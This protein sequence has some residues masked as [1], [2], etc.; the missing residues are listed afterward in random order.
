MDEKT[1]LITRLIAGLT[2]F[3]SM[4]SLN[5]VGVICGIVLG[6]GSFALSW[7]YKDKN[8]KLLAEQFGEKFAEKVSDD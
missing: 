4:A 2:T 1:D 3:F 5:D 8:H 6:L 7:Y